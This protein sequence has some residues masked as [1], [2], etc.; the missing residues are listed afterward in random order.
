[1]T[2]VAPAPPGMDE[3]TSVKPSTFTIAHISI[4]AAA[5]LD[6]TPIFT[7]DALP[8]RLTPEP[9]PLKKFEVRVPS[10]SSTKNE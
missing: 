3:S 5:P 6:N 9:L 8:P 7:I 10:V 1:M 4:V 2:V